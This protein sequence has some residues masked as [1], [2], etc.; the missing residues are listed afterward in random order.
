MAQ[1]LGMVSIVSTIVA[2]VVAILS[3]VLPP[4]YAGAFYKLLDAA[5]GE[6]PTY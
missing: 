5:S 3:V 6:H 4:P 1:T 2:V